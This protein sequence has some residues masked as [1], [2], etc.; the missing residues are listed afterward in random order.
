MKKELIRIVTIGPESTGKSSLCASLAKAYHTL[1]CPEYAREFL[2]QLKEDEHKGSLEAPY[3]NYTYDDLLIIA[4][5]Q[6]ALEN[7]MAEKAVEYWENQLEKK[8]SK[9][10]LFIDTDMYVMKVW[11]EEVFGKCH[12]FILE[13]IAERS[14]DFY[15]L[16]GTDLPWVKDELR[17]YP[18]LEKRNELLHVYQDILVQQHIPW[19]K[20]NG[21]GE[22]RMHSAMNAIQKEFPNLLV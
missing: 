13:Q 14:Y 15:L 20:V 2:V 19:E 1:W 9:P 3:G 12:P 6:L 10:V 18:D 21:K 16:C 22:A 11:C 17:E 4:K 8:T 7:E 5:G